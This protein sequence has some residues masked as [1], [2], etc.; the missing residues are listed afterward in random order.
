MG[1][2]ILDNMRPLETNLYLWYY[3][4][5]HDNPCQVERRSVE[6]VLPHSA[7]VTFGPIDKILI[8]ASLSHPL[9]EELI[10]KFVESIEYINGLE[11]TKIY[12]HENS[13]L[14]RL[15]SLNSIDYNAFRTIEFTENF[16]PGS[17]VIL[18][19]IERVP[20]R[21]SIEER[22]NGKSFDAYSIPN[23][24][25]LTYC[26]LQGQISIL[27]KIRFNN[28][29]KHPFIIYF[30]QGNWLMDYISTRIK[31]HSNTKQLGECYEDIF[32]HI[33]NLSC[34]IIPS[35][36][37]LILNKSYK[38]IKEHSL[39]FNESVYSFIINICSRTKSTINL[40]N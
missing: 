8:E 17:I 13:S 31:I 40:I 6:D 21:S 27:D 9:N 25:K 36:F 39:K 20:Y 32:S 33:K 38:L 22:S 19:D 18:I 16:C 14:I 4:Q 5:A 10:K 2:F 26:S 24:G 23:Y 28:D 12:V 15:T 30:K 3:D 35:Y 7:I 11:R 34:L 37:D 1:S 29:L